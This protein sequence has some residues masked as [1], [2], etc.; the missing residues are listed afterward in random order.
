MM[1]PKPRRARGPPTGAYHLFPLG[2]ELEEDVVGLE[3]VQLEQA[4]SRQDAPAR[5]AHVGVGGRAVRLQ[6]KR[7]DR[8]ERTHAQPTP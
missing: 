8:H 7:V 2:H 4:C 6:C 3:H 1:S 5:F